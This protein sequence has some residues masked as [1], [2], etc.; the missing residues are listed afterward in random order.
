[1]A[2]GVFPTSARAGRA[3]TAIFGSTAVRPMAT[4]FGVVGARGD[5]PSFTA[6]VWQTRLDVSGRGR[7]NLLV[8]HAM[9]TV[10]ARSISVRLTMD[11]NVVLATTVSMPTGATLLELIGNVNASSDGTYTVM[12][13]ILHSEYFDSNC[14][15]EVMNSNTESG[16]VQIY[17]HLNLTK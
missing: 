13:P 15:L 16:Y 9:V 7:L 14:K 17:T 2:G 11:G 3:T 4:N 10:G 1:M 6:G 12:V 8:V 5:A